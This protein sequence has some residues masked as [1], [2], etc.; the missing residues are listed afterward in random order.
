MKEK[1]PTG[2]RKPAQNIVPKKNVQGSYKGPSSVGKP[3]DLPPPPPKK[4]KG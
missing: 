4:K 1:K 3:K 2:K